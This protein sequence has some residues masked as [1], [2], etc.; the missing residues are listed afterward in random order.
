MGK[1]GIDNQLSGQNSSG[2]CNSTS[3]VEKQ[4]VSLGRIF[5]LFL[6][7]K[8]KLNALKTGKL[9]F[10]FLRGGNFYLRAKAESL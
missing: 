5:F 2:I 9:D 4:E 8:A 7:G 10:I 1:N 6:P 3:K